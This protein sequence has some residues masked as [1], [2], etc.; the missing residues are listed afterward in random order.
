MS[1]NTGSGRNQRNNPYQ[2][3]EL[4]IKFH[5]SPAG[6][7]WRWRTELLVMSG[8]AVIFWRLDTWTSLIWAG[9][10]LAVLAAVAGAVPHSRRFITRRA[11]CVPARHRRQ[12]LCYEAR[13]HTRSGRLPLI[14]WT[15]PTKVGERSWLLCRAGICAEDFEAHI[16]ELRAACYARDARITRNRRWS[17][18]ITIDIIRRDTLAASQIIASPLERLT[19]RYHIGQLELVPDPDPGPAPWP[20][21]PDGWA[22]PDPNSPGGQGEPAA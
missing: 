4:F 19:A 16:G 22:N 13:L 6:I 5:R 7:A 3:D 9:I 17:H 12:R 2:L 8:L 10:I 1:K 21:A 18:L 15:R 11:W 14:L 20:G